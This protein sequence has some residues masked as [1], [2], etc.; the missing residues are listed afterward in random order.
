MFFQAFF[1]AKPVHVVSGF[2]PINSSAPSA[3]NMRQLTG[4][5]LV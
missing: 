3:A 2:L 1:D 5:A 4:S